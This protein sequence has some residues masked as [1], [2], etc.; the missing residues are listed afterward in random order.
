MEGPLSEKIV[1]IK[2]KRNPTNI[3]RLWLNHKNISH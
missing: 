2:E 3:R 1:E